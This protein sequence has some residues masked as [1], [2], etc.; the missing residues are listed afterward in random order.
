MT[1]TQMK[2]GEVPGVGQPISRLVQGSIQIDMKNE[3]AAFP[4]L[5]AAFERGEIGFV[6]R[7]GAFVHR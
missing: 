5:D 1:N 4:L 2:Y 7:H 3:D 6:N